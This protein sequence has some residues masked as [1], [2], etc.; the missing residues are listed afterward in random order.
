MAHLDS[1]DSQSPRRL[2]EQELVGPPAKSRWWLWLLIAAILVVGFWY[3]RGSHS[4][5]EAESSKNA[6]AGAAQGAQG[7]QGSGAGAGAG[8]GGKAGAGGGMPQVPV[9]VATAKKG[10][11]PVYFSGL[12]TVTAFNTVTVHSRV[13]GQLIKVNF[14]EGQIVHEGEVLAEIDPRPF[15]VVLE[16]AQG[17]LAKDVAQRK[18]AQTNLERYKLLFGEGV[19]PKQQMDTQQ[20]QVGQFDGSIAADQGAIDSAKLQL[21][22]THVTAPLTGRVGLR[23]VDAGNMV[24]AAD[25][26]GLVVITQLQ[27]ISV[28]FSLPQDQLPQVASKLHGGGQLP[29]DAYDRDNTTKI[30][31]GI[32]AS[33]DN[34]IDTTTGTYKLKARFNNENN[35]LYPNQ[36]VNMHLLVD[37]K[38]NLIIVP[39]AAIQ[40]GP[41][42]STYVYVVDTGTSTV[43][44]HNVKIEQATDNQVGISDGINDGDVVVIDGADKLQDGSKV[45]ATQAPNNGKPA[46]NND[47]PAQQ[48]QRQSQQQQPQNNSGYK[49]KGKKQ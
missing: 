3:W 21:S 45:A 46:A 31:S 47:N 19:I 5:A 1:T 28:I 30:A 39:T 29:V 18:D 17:N 25:A 24:H 16:Q 9:V 36:F 33:I 12:G 43:K 8:R 23:L 34:Q 7:A 14:T 48:P 49:G 44:I 32:L 20:A 40:R 38:K 27:P 37:T 6:Q 13:D 4:N 22:F 35:V 42:S 11:L 10:D 15:Q 41:N 26:G 2:S